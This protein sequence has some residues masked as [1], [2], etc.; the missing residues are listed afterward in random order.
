VLSL[1]KHDPV[2]LSVAVVL[3]SRRV[4]LFDLD[5]TIHDAGAYVFGELHRAMTAYVV[6]ELDV[7]HDHA[8]AL[9]H[10]YWQ[11]YGATLIGLVRH[12][13]VD[14][15]HFLH[16]THRLPQLDAMLRAH[17]RDIA[18]IRRLQGRRI[19]LTNAPYAYAMRVLRGLRIAQ[20][21]DDVI[22]I[23]SMRM[24]GQWRPKPDARM[25][26]RLLARLKVAP[27]RCVLVEDT[28]VHQRAAHAFGIKAAWMQRYARPKSRAPEVGVHQPLKPRYVYARI[29]SLQHL[30]RLK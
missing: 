7:S 25:F 1:S 2:A 22:S 10:A 8:D 19:V 9:R 11:R 18:A 26:A 27:T 5:N 16:H 12:H 6:R 3:S 15:H 17:P 23:E 30:R 20:L 4:W 13:D 28:L 21:F 24:F 29:T 14:G